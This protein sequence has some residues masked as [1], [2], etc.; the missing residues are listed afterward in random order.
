MPLSMHTMKYACRCICDVQYSQYSLQA[1]AS[2]AVDNMFD[3]LDALLGDPANPDT[4]LI[5]S[6]LISQTNL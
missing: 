4:N 5:E 3:N 6:K 1:A 2:A